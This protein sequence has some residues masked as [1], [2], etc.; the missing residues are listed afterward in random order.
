[1]TSECTSLA[2]SGLNASL[3]SSLVPCL[4]NSLL[5]APFVASFSKISL[6]TPLSQRG[7]GRSRLRR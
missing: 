7:K 5:S 1:M 2:L 6:Q 4:P 3:A